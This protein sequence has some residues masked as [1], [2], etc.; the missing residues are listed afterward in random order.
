M[1]G[2]EKKRYRHINLDNEKDFLNILD[3]VENSI[4]TLYRTD[5]LPIR[6]DLEN[7]EKE[8]L[9]TDIKPYFVGRR[10]FLN[11]RCFD[12]SAN[13]FLN[14]DIDVYIGNILIIR[15]PRGYKNNYVYYCLV[16]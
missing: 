4:C 10:L 15:L 1:F 2:F 13:K 9:D 12:M 5:Y 11:D 8:C 6:K 7:I 3:W 14:K 16:K